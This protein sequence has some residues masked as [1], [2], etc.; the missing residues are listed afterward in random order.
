MRKQ[1]SIYIDHDIVVM[2]KKFGIFDIP[3]GLKKNAIYEGK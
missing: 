3:I 1:S 2:K